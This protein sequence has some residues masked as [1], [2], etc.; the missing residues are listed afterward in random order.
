[1]ATSLDSMS[2]YR[3]R[4]S[5]V[6]VPKF[7]SCGGNIEHSRIIA[8]IFCTLAALVTHYCV[9]DAWCFLWLTVVTGKHSL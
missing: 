1:M 8:I 6:V 3:C 4:P 9:R 5:I 7:H 2:L